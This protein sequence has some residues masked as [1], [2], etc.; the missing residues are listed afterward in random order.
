[1]AQFETA[2]SQ[3]GEAHEPGAQVKIA[4]LDEL[5]SLV[6]ASVAGGLQVPMRAAVTTLFVLQR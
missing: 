2:E 4:T 6:E 5:I 3:N 1:M